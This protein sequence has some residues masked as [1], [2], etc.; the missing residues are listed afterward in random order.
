V[1][2]EVGSLVPEKGGERG[3]DE[4]RPAAAR[5]H[6]AAAGQAGNGA[7]VPQNV[8]PEANVPSGS[9]ACLTS[10]S[11]SITAGG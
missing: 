8:W 4:R 2:E 10:R 1:P 11:R 3:A 7:L 5:G 9:T 6:G